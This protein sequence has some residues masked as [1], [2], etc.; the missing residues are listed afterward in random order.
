MQ[1]HHS[2]NDECGGELLE[3]RLTN[4]Y[5]LVAFLGGLRRHM[6]TRPMQVQQASLDVMVSCIRE[7]SH[8]V[9]KY[10]MSNEVQLMRAKCEEMT[11]MYIEKVRFQQSSTTSIVD[12]VQDLHSL[13]N[14]LD[15]ADEDLLRVKRCIQRLEDQHKKTQD[16]LMLQ[17]IYRTLLSYDNQYLSLMNH[18][19]D[20][21]NRM[22]SY[23]HIITR[24]DVLQAVEEL[25]HVLYRVHHP[26]FDVR[27][28]KCVSQH[29]LLL[30]D[31]DFD[32]NTVSTFEGSLVDLERYVMV[33]D[34]SDGDSEF[35][36]D[37][38]EI[39]YDDVEM[40]APVTEVLT[41]IGQMKM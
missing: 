6:V 3:R 39:R 23:T 1:R 21:L 26:E 29:T 35:V 18:R 12:D 15:D 22:Q 14:E 24:E 16:K 30:L 5:N 4:R 38:D 7:L 20:V 36:E 40:Q 19:Y 13:M 37:V 10:G 31:S 8:L 25:R 27:F 11:S 9:E 28:K 2:V 17:R 34:G 41:G 33:H 32:E